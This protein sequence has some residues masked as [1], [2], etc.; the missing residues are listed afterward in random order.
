MSVKRPWA[1]PLVPVYAAAIRL[2]DWL[3]GAGVG[4]TRRLRWR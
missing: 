2:K 4:R 1:R 3:R